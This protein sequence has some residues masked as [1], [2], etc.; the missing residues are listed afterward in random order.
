ML[1]QL[2]Y[3]PVHDHTSGRW[4][5]NPFSRSHNPLCRA[6]YTTPCHDIEMAR[7]ERATPR[8]RSECSPD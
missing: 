6:T 8:S 5:L 2:S 1:Y 7:L 3:S 4:D